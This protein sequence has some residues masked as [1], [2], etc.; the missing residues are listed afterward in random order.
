MNW[1]TEPEADGSSGMDHPWNVKP[2]PDWT[3]APS[4]HSETGG[5][6]GLVVGGDGTQKLDI[7]DQIWVPEGDGVVHMSVPPHLRVT[8]GARGASSISTVLLIATALLTA[9]G[10][11]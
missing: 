3:G 6:T 4:G 5:D 8:T 7:P 11:R 2:S 10:L 9:A 1:D